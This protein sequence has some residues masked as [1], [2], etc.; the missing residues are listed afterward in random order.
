MCMCDVFL[1]LGIFSVL[2]CVTSS[3]V[4]YGCSVWYVNFINAITT[5]IAVYQYIC[6]ARTLPTH[7]Q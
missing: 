4:V 3:R 2:L 6:M 7:K 5:I 1:V